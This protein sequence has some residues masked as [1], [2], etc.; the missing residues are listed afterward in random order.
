MAI[1]IVTRMLRDTAGGAPTSVEAPAG[2]KVIVLDA[3]KLP[4]TKIRLEASGAEGWVSDEA[5]N[6]TANALGPLDRKEVAWEC[7]DIANTLGPNAFY[8]MAVAQLRSNVSGVQIPDSPCI[9]PFGFSPDEWAANAAKPDFQVVFEKADITR[10]RA[11]TWIFAI[12][13]LSRQLDM[14]IAMDK[15][16]SMAQ[17]LLGQILGAKTAALAIQTPATKRD[18][19]LEMAKAEAATSGIDIANLSARDAGLL[20]AD[21][22]ACLAIIEEKLET[23]FE[24][25]RS[26][27]RTEVDIFIK[28]SLTM[29][30]ALPAGTVQ[31]RLSKEL[32]D[33]GR[34]PIADM[35][36]GKFA[37]QGYGAIAQIAAVAN[38]IHES[39][40]NPNAENLNGERSFGLFQLN[41]KGGVGT[42]FPEAELKDPERN[43]EIM[44]AE[45]AKPYLKTA[46]TQF[47]TTTSLFEAVDIFVRR[48]ERPADQTNEVNKRFKTAQSLIA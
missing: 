10:W 44:L 27:V 15:Q 25:V 11:Q 21:G 3:T 13:A 39:R 42:G 19:L 37:E 16:P 46:R 31:V 43:I 45:I 28:T 9:G 30:D 33:K 12:N 23:A 41:Q 38:A 8:L 17:L 22:A 7:V 2:A 6:K 40:L 20:G 32:V 48:F 36:A 26:V 1:M 35:I 29:G 14:A 24:A 34:Q 47:R 18:T 4:W 5:I